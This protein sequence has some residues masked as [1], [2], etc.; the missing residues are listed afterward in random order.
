MRRKTSLD[1][2]IEWAQN[3]V[4]RYYPNFKDA[5]TRYEELIKSSLNKGMIVLDAGCGKAGILGKHVGEA[6]TAVGIDVDRE[7]LKGNVLL[8]NLVVGNLEEL[9]FKD[10]TLDVIACQWVLEHLKEPQGALRELYRT[11]KK[12]GQ[13]VVVT[14]NIYNYVMILSRLMP[15]NLKQKI[16]AK[17]GRG[18]SDTFPT[19]YRCNS[20]SKLLKMTE[21]AGFQK[22]EFHLVGNPF[23][24]FT[25]K[26]LFA[27]AVL[28]EKLT[29]LPFL[30]KGKIHMVA[31][32]VKE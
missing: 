9:P 28:Y 30:G 10:E 24:F 5:E 11:L 15:L 19:Y 14:S 4:N 7:S 16:L 25:S 3:F 1:Q 27:L 12:G 26:H 20:P 2:K 29:D 6:K 17:L 21:S 13:L 22:E 18:E 23:Y 31:L 32:F 8:N